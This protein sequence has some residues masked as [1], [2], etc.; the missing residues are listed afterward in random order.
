MMTHART[1]KS[2]AGIY[3]LLD[4]ARLAH[5]EPQKLRRWLDGYAYNANGRRGRSK[6]VFRRDRPTERILS[7][8]DLIEVSFVTAFLRE[9]LS[10]HKIRDFEERAASELKTTHPFCTHQFAT[11]GQTI[12]AKVN[13]G[14][15]PRVLDLKRR[16]FV[17]KKV[18]S[19]LLRNLDFGTDDASR[20][21]PL[22]KDRPVVIDPR[23]AFGAPT[24]ARSSVPT[25]ILF[26]AV[27]SGESVEAIAEWYSVGVDEVEAARELEEQLV[28]P[29]RPRV[30]A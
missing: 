10:M 4:A 14:G 18:I 17:F 11:D 12:F 5:I 7:F 23:V 15:V 27:Q 13:W 19:P 9:G 24:V 1:A 30:A 3:P 6:P 29:R 21:W 16:Q 26:G 20:L 2:A 8:R 25:R 28:P 22:G